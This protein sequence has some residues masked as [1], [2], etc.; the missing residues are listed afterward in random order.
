[1]GG[2]GYIVFL[3]RAFAG[4][5][6]F[7]GFAFAAGPGLTQTEV[8]VEVCEAAT[9]SP[10]PPPARTCFTSETCDRDSLKYPAFYDIHYQR[11]LLSKLSSPFGE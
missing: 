6:A 10:P 8:D 9:V 7:G 1:M 4:Y 2:L 11:H 5:L 3:S